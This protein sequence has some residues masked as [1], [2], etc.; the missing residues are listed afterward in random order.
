MTFDF[1]NPDYAQEFKRRAENLKRIRENPEQVGVLKAYYRE[2]IAD[3][4]CDWG[5]TSDPRNA[6]RG[7]PVVIPFVLFPRQREWIE[8]LLAR[9]IGQESGL[10]EKSRDMGISWLSIAAACSI[11]LFYDDLNIGFG[12]RKEEYVDKIGDPKSLFY[13]ARQFMSLLPP[14]FS[15]GWN[16]KTDS[17]H[18][19]IKF[20]NTSSTLTGEAGD[21]IGRG[22]RASIYFKDE[23]AFYERPQLIDAALSQTSNCKIDISTPNGSGTPFYQKRFSGKISVFTFHWK[24]DPRKDQAWYDK[25]CDE[26]DPVT[27]AQEIDIDYNASVSGITIPGKYVQAAVNLHESMGLQPSGAIRC[28]LDVADEEGND[29]NVLATLKG[30]VVTG[31][32]SWGG[33]D[34]TETGN[35]AMALAREERAQYVNFDSIGVGAGVRGATKMSSILFNP[36][37]VSESPTLGNVLNS[38]KKLNRDHYM[39][40]RAQLWWEMRIRCERAFEHVTGKKLWALDDMVSIPNHPQLIAELSQPLHEYTDGGK[41]QIESKKKMKKRGVNSPNYADAVLLGFVKPA[42]RVKSQKAEQAAAAT[43]P[44]ARRRANKSSRGWT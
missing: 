18:M 3:F 22:N 43:A 4:I 42:A 26:L 10:T 20:P 13:K 35:K 44:S 23:S 15:G 21:N 28:G 9:W 24:Q 1:R 8:W 34:T 17:S 31:L 27:V 19:L 12:S 11:C 33:V 29:F 6:E 38:P 32:E 41:I 25:Q 5:M 37:A 40:L 7:L 16:D 39:N 14:E 36:V 2:N 30:T